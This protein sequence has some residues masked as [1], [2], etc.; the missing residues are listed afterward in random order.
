M[1][2]FLLRKMICLFGKLLLLRLLLFFFFS[3]DGY[4]IVCRWFPV[5]SWAFTSLR[6]F[7]P[8][9]YSILVWMTFFNKLPIEDQL[10]GQGVLL[11]HQYA[12]Y[13]AVTLNPLIT[14]FSCE[15]EQR[16]WLWFAA[17][18]GNALLVT[19]SFSKFWL[20]FMLKRF[21]PQL[22]NVWL[23]AVANDY[24]EDTK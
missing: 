17:Q 7:I 3:S 9:R 8:R 5:Q 1:C 10:Q 12:N 2:L 21:P 23:V 15:F 6:P 20:S 14:N 18:F 16:A 4:E 13:V 24:L 19:G 22:R 11:W